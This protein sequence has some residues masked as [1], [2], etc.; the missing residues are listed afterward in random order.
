MQI[1]QEQMDT[2]SQAEITKFD[3]RIA[4]F[5]QSQFPDAP[6]IPREYLMPVIHEQVKTARS[7]GLETE[8]QIG[9]FVTTAWLLGSQFD[10][11]FPAAQEMLKSSEYTPDEKSEWLAQW[12]EEMFA[13]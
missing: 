6:E 13:A 3:A 7:Y 11:D 2:F 5:L 4:D 10:T 12:T 8:R 9:N 1:R